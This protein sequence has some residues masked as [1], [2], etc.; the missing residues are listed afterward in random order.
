M[1]MVDPIEK[2]KVH[3]L[4]AWVLQSLI[5]P[6]GDFLAGQGMIGHLQFLK[7]AQWWSRDELLR[8]QTKALKNLIDIAYREVPFYRACMDER[9]LRPQHFQSIEDLAKLPV[10]TKE[11]IRKHY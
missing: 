5:L 1:K 11:I 7:N 6:G 8:F 3:K 9:D 2:K 4:W 10:L